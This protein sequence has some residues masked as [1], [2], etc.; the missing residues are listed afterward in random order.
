[1]ADLRVTGFLGGGDWFEPRV[2]A[3]NGLQNVLN[4]YRYFAEKLEGQVLPA[5]IADAL[6]P[7][8]TL[9]RDVYCPVKTGDLRASGYVEA[10][11]TS[12]GRVEAEIGFARDGIPDYAIMVHENPEA[13]HTAPTQYKFLERAVHETSMDVMDRVAT[14][15]KQQMSL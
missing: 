4:D 3:F 9:A 10:R 5:A 12:R 14:D 1:M 7:T 6:E 11:R 8:L 13:F 2:G 15:V